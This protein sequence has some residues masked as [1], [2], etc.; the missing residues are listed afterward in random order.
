MLSWNA[1]EVNPSFIEGGHSLLNWVLLSV[2]ND[3]DEV[4]AQ[5]KESRGWE[6]R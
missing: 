6:L 3:R 5:P 1:D 4:H 2:V